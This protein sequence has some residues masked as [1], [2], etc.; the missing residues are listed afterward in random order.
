MGSSPSCQ[1]R[2]N[3]G[4]PPE[5]WGHP[6]RSGPCALATKHVNI[7]I[8]LV[9]IVHIEG[10]FIHAGSKTFSLP[11]G[12]KD[13]RC[14]ISFAHLCIVHHYRILTRWRR[15][16]IRGPNPCGIHGNHFPSIAEGG[17][18]V[19]AMRSEWRGHNED[20][21]TLHGAMKISD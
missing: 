2:L 16:S 21:E 20:G 4:H 6:K 12:L 13:N 14:W 11:T 9:K 3:R 8:E 17:R 5:S 1:F 15:D 19:E 10:T 7:E 18:G